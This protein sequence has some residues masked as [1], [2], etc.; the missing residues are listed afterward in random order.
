MRIYERYATLA[1]ALVALAAMGAQA[2]EL[3]ADLKQEVLANCMSDAY[4][5]CPQSLGSVSEAAACM[6]GK[7]AQL[8]PLCRVAFDRAARVLAQK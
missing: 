5:L 1:G 8:T 6:R 3:S 2:G 7:H 4:R